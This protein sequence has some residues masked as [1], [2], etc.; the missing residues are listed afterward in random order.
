[1]SDHKTPHT[2]ETGA[3]TAAEVAAAEAPTLELVHSQSNAEMYEQVASEWEANH[4]GDAYLGSER[5]QALRAVPDESPEQLKAHAAAKEKSRRIYER[6]IPA[7]AAGSVAL[8][9]AIPAA[10]KL[11]GVHDRAKTAKPEAALIQTAN[12]S[13]RTAAPLGET[14]A[15]TEAQPDTGYT[16][17]ELRDLPAQ[18]VTIPDGKGAQYATDVADAG[19]R[20]DHPEL[21]AQIDNIVQGIPAN[22]VLQRG[23]SYGVPK[24]SN[25]S[26]PSQP[27]Q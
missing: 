27:K 8:A 16:D 17:E 9:L 1:M 21:A 25:Y 24:M 4:P 11:F 20:L 15:L 14:S 3:P 22:G 6:L 7:V 12:G 18:Q 5:Q 2:P 23:T 19:L 13:E 10:A 26:E